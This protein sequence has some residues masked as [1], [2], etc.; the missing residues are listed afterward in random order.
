MG[1]GGCEQ[2][3]G[4][5]E[6]E[7]RGGGGEG[8]REPSCLPEKPKPVCV[9]EKKR[10]KSKVRGP[11]AAIG[12]LVNLCVEGGGEVVWMWVGKYTQSCKSTRKEHTNTRHQMHVCALFRRPTVKTV[13]VSQGGGVKVLLWRT[14]QS[15]RAEIGR[16]HA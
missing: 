15:S 12:R 7:G 11:T 13:T 5:G 6:E 14:S 1:V 9:G 4:G 10:F 16:G 8:K 3:E 2:W